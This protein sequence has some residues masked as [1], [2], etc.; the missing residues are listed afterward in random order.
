MEKYFCSCCN[1]IKDYEVINKAQKQYI[2]YI[3][4]KSKKYK[5]NKI[6]DEY[7]CDE[8]I[9]VEEPKLLIIM[10][11]LENSD[12]LQEI[13]EELMHLIKTLYVQGDSATEILELLS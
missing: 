4:I 1:E 7:F 9:S 13:P 12:N 5:L 2:L 11:D 10:S 6:L 8:C 3:D